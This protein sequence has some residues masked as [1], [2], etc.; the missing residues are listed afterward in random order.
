MCLAQIEFV[1]DGTD[2]KRDSLTDIAWVERT[3]AGLK[4][5]DLSGNITELAAE[6]RSIDFVESVVNVERRASP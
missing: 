4:V 3:P 6:I 5:V 2:K 1:S